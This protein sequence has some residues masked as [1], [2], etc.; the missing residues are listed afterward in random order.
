VSESVR[1]LQVNVTR[2]GVPREPVAE[3][4]AAGIS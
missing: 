3:A 1:V 2:T 4:L